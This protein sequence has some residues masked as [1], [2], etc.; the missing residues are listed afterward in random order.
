MVREKD[1]RLLLDEID[2]GILYMLQ[3]NARTTTHDEISAEVGV[4]PSTVRNRIG[5]LE[6]AGIIEGYMPKIDYERA[7]FPLHV[8]LVCTA[9]SERSQRAQEALTVN[10]VVNV[11][12]T[13]LRDPGRTAKPQRLSAV[14]IRSC[15]STN[16]AGSPG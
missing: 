6:E 12:D 1:E 2:R 14:S 10:G 15:S 11:R 13:T 8:Q 16:I 3:E 5:Q 7:G 9:S 4:S